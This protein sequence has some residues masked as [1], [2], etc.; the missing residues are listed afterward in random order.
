[1]IIILPK[2]NYETVKTYTTIKMH[3]IDKNGRKR[4]LVTMKSPH[5]YS[6]TEINFA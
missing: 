4:P 1:M 2:S 3:F 6:K 5:K